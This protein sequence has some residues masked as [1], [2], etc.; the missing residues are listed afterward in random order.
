MRWSRAIKFPTAE[1]MCTAAGVSS[2]ELQGC[3]SDE[4]SAAEFVGA[5]LD[6]NGFLTDGRIDMEQIQLSAQL[7][8]A[9]P[10][11]DATP[12]ADPLSDRGPA[13]DPTLSA[14]PVDSFSDAGP[15]GDNSGSPAQVALFCL[16]SA[17]DDWLKMHDC[18]SRNDPASR[19]DGN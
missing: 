5:W 1:Q 4:N 12:A 18:I 19:L 17:S 15:G 10:D 7:D 11:P 3:I 14:D 16:N 6:L 13:A 8:A 9:D 2:A